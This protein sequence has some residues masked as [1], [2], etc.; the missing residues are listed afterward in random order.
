MLMSV[1]NGQAYLAEA[2]ESILSQA[3]GDFE[4]L[5]ID[6]GSVDAT[7][8][9]LAEYARR[10]SRVRV[11]TQENR[12]RVLSLNRGLEMVRAPLVARM[13][14]DD[15]SLPK[16]LEM[17]VAFLEAHPEIGL[18]GTAVEMIGPKNEPLGIYAPECDDE[19]L[20]KTLM[21]FNPFRH[22]TIVMRKELASALGGYRNVMLDTD[23]Y[24]L[25]LRMAEQTKIANLPDALVK[26]R[27]HPKQVSVTNV[28]HQTICCR[29]AVLG[30]VQ[31]RRGLP[32]PLDAAKEIT[33]EFVIG[34]G[35]TS[36]ELWR[37]ISAAYCH[38]I[39]TFFD[40]QPDDALELVRRFLEA[41]TKGPVDRGCLAD[42]L[43]MGARINVRRRRFLDAFAFAL[44]GIALSPASAGRI[45]RLAIRRRL[46][47]MSPRQ[48]QGNAV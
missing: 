27:V 16:R 11:V 40:S 23:D 17:Q 24:D 34:L 5:I 37:E 13:D 14:A 42:A 4:F 7:A 47:D 1:Y 15:V 32:D 6:D 8:Q 35:A 30:A 19:V 43:L 41:R 29:A 21:R 20:Q 44:R 26:Y 22:P 28:A 25:W 38:W 10:D 3:F 36:E 33:P 48:M 12:G 46:N 45:V 2:V 18:L 9:M 39:S 31:R